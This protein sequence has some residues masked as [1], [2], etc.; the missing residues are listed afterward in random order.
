MKGLYLLFFPLFFFFGFSYAQ[1]VITGE[2]LD[3]ESDVKLSKATIMLI[4]AQDSILVDF[5]RAADNGK[6]TLNKPTKGAYLLIVSY[7]KYA[8][9][10]VEIQGGNEPTDVGEVSL[11][12]IAQMLE[13]VVVTGRIPIVIKGDT[14]EYDAS[15]FTVEKNAKVED[16]LKVL[17]GITVDAS[18]KI[19]AQGKTVEKVLVDGEEFF[20]DDPVLVTRNIRSDMVDKVQVYEKKSDQAERTGVDDGQRTQ[21]INLQLKDDAKRG[22]FGKVE[23]GGATDDFYIGQGMLNYFDQSLKV[24]AFVIG[25]NNGK[26]DLSGEESRLLDD[27]NFGDGT[28][29]GEGQPRSFSTGALYTDKSKDKKHTWRVDYKFNESE[30]DLRRDIYQR[31][32]FR[33]TILESNYMTD[34][35]SYNNRHNVSIKHESK[36]DSLT[37]LTVWA[38]ANRTTA[39]GVSSTTSATFNQFAEQIN[40]NTRDLND[41]NRSEAYNLNAIFTRRFNKPGR[42]VSLSYNING[43]ENE[44]EQYLKSATK[45]Y[46]GGLVD[47]D[48]IIDQYKESDN[49]H[50]HQSGSISYSEPILKDLVVTLEYKLSKDLNNNILESFNKNQSTGMYDELDEIYS[51]DFEYQTKQHSYNLTLNYKLNDNISFNISNYLVD[52]ELSQVNK[53]DG[54]SMSRSFFVYNPNIGANLKL[55]RSKSMNIR[56]LG[57]NTLPTLSQ[58]QPL[59]SNLDPLN[60]YIGNEN[61][62]NSYAHNFNVNMWSSNILTG[63]FWGFGGSGANVRDALVQNVVTDTL[64][65]N[66]YTWENMKGKNNN[67]LNM[68]AWY[69]TPLLK[70]YQIYHGMNVGLNYNSNYNYINNLLAQAETQVYSLGYGWRKSTTKGLDF[71]VNLAPNYVIQKNSIG[72]APDSRG[73]GFNGVGNFKYFLPAKWRLDADIQYLYEAST[74]VYSEKFD[75]LL[76]HPSL[77]RKFLPNE[78][79]VLSFVVND[80]FNQNVGFSRDQSGTQLTERRYNTIGR[81]YMLKLTWEINKMFTISN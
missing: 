14:T 9:Y 74:D 57:T 32:S 80:L 3:E 18:G 47:N 60:E 37:T 46:R 7:P 62:T 8:D 59:R 79:L 28:F 39:N 68:Y 71:D 73:F 5:T 55:G 25:S 75:R 56:Y 61:L 58:I 42:A 29:G 72:I 15:S 77:S 20:G 69:Y 13:E 27:D 36:F 44:G 49:S 23:A 26:T 78:T 30:V 53:Y 22:M 48:S 70:K 21:T 31:N 40:D 66:T 24:A 34:A 45:Y 63:S 54:H 35:D 38:G 6:F 33:D 1:S 52:S 11:T 2:I 50:R 19:T 16:L 43:S 65:K 67:S 12:S 81:Y 17:P 51:N 4:Q 76:I 41:K 10:S 64:G